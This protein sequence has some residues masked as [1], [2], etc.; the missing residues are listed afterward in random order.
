MTIKN[1]KHFFNLFNDFIV[2]KYLNTIYLFA[3]ITKKKIKKSVNK[4]NSTSF[5][6]F[7]IPF[8]GYAFDNHLL[9]FSYDFFNNLIKKNLPTF[10]YITDLHT[11][12]ITWNTFNYTEQF[13]K[14]NWT[15][16]KKFD[17]FN[18]AIFLTFNSDIK[19]YT[20]NEYLGILKLTKNC[21]SSLMNNLDFSE[22]YFFI[23]RH[24]NKFLKPLKKKNNFNL[25]NQI[26]INKNSQKIFLKFKK[27]NNFKKIHFWQSFFYEL[28]D[29]PIKLNSI[30]VFNEFSK[31]NINSFSKE[32]SIF[33]TESPP[34]PLFIEN[35]PTKKNKIFINKNTILETNIENFFYFK[36]TNNCF[37]F[38]Y[39]FDT[40]T[41]N[42]K[43]IN[44][45]IFNISHSKFISPLWNSR[46]FQYSIYNTFS[47]F[48][49]FI[50]FQ[51]IN[52]TE[53][54]KIFFKNFLNLQSNETIL[55][56]YINCKHAFRVDIRNLILSNQRFE[57]C[58]FDNHFN[59]IPTIEKQIS[60]REYQPHF[61]LK[62]K[63]KSLI[64]LFQKEFFSFLNYKPKI[65][66]N[67]QK[68]KNFNKLFI[69]FNTKNNFETKKKSNNFNQINCYSEKN[70]FLL[71]KNLF[72]IPSR[73]IIFF[74]IKNSIRIEQTEFLKRRLSGYKYP[75]IS[76]E[77]LN[78]KLII[79]HPNNIAQSK[80]IKSI[81]IIGLKHII[82]LKFKQL[83]NLQN[84]FFN[85]YLKL[86]NS[87]SFENR[88]NIHFKS[89]Q[90]QFFFN[91]LEPNFFIKL[92][93]K[94]FESG[95]KKLEENLAKEK[96]NLEENVK[97][98][99]QNNDKINLESNNKINLELNYKKI[100]NY[101]LNFLYFNLPMKLE[102]NSE[103]VSYQEPLK[104]FDFNSKIFN[105]KKKNF[106]P[107]VEEIFETKT[108]FLY[109]NHLVENQQDFN[110]QFYYQN[111]LKSNF[112]D[113][114]KLL[115]PITFLEN[116]LEKIQQIL[117]NKFI[118]KNIL[119]HF[120]SN[121]KIKLPLIYK[122][123]NNF[124]RL[125]HN[126][127]QFKSLKKDIHLYESI[128]EK[129]IS[130]LTQIIF[131]LV[132][133]KKLDSLRKVYQDAINLALESF[134]SELKVESLIDLKEAEYK[135]I[136]ESKKIKFK[137]LAGGAFFLNKFSQ[138]LLLLKNSKKRF[139]QFNI[140]LPTKLSLIK[141]LKIK[142]FNS[143]SKFFLTILSFVYILKKL[144][145]KPKKTIIKNQIEEQFVS[146]GFIIVGPPGSG[147]TVLVK[148]LAGEA[149]VPIII[150]SG[151]AYIKSSATDDMKDVARLKQIFRL[152]KKKA[153]CILFIDEIDNIGQN[154]KDVSTY[155][156]AKQITNQNL[157]PSIKDL[158]KKS[159]RYWQI[160]NPVL[161]NSFLV[162]NEIK[163]EIF[164]SEISNSKKIKTL[165]MLTQFLCE[166][167]GI[168]NRKDIIIIGTTNRLESLDP[169]LIRPGRLDQVV[170]VTFPNKHKRL[171]LLKKSSQ[172][173]NES[174]INW[175]IFINQTS[176][177]TSA[178]I[179]S[180]IQISI[181]KT[182]YKKFNSNFLLKKK[183]N[184]LQNIINKI[185]NQPKFLHDFQTIEYGIEIISTRTNDLQYNSYQN[186][187][188]LNSLIFG[189][190][191]Y[192]K[193]S[194]FSSL[195]NQFF[196][197]THKNYN[198]ILPFYQKKFINLFYTK[199]NIFCDRLKNSYYLFLYLANKFKLKLQK[200]NINLKKLEKNSRNKFYQKYRKYLRILYLLQ[201]K[202]INNI[203]LK[204]NK[205]SLT[206]EKLI[207]STQL[208]KFNCYINRIFKMHL[209]GCQLLT[210]STCSIKNLLIFSFQFKK[211]LFSHQHL[212]KYKLLYSST[213][214]LL[215]NH[216]NL[217]KIPNFIFNNSFDLNRILYCI[218]GKTLIF[219]LLNE[220]NLNLKRL[221]FW[222][223]LQPISEKNNESKKFFQ[224]LFNNCIIKKQFEN[225][226]LFLISGKATEISIIQNYMF[227]NYSNLENYDLQKI[228]WLMSIMIE[229][230]LF[231]NSIKIS[232]LKQINIKQIQ[233]KIKSNKLNT[234]LLSKKNA[235]NKNKFSLN[236][237][238]KRLNLLVALF[239]KHIKNTNNFRQIES[240]HTMPYWWES[241]IKNQILIKKK[242]NNFYGN[243]Y[244]FFMLA[245]A[246]KIQNKILAKFTSYDFYFYNLL[247]NLTSLKN[248]SNKQK[249]IAFFNKKK[250]SYIHDFSVNW[251][252]LQLIESNYIIANLLF[253]SFNKTFKIIE[254]NKEL[255]DCF[256]YYFLCTE[257]LY[258]FE[259]IHFVKN[260]L[261]LK[262]FNKN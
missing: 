56:T 194:I 54:E 157:I 67:F 24:Y 94:E 32:T 23:G 35:F 191:H 48:R 81:K 74:N 137:N 216:F 78:K 57:K 141:V 92:T 184:N 97:T 21:E 247:N 8:V 31:L 62:K 201:N 208:N 102:N 187:C 199:S 215:N 159:N 39:C 133:A 249:L 103:S 173:K 222:K 168:K 245:P 19:F 136:I 115:Q 112:K 100:Q 14:I 45:F 55:K 235:F 59:Q 50:N 13:K 27:F 239:D 96:Q 163:Q 76:R 77:N 84:T 30:F 113:H 126:F 9:L 153:P 5:F 79:H 47:F 256:A 66:Y 227:T 101:I 179:I 253:E 68:K 202:N 154:R 110:T 65:F 218:S 193:K 166:I 83:I 200:N 206:L 145:T 135:G 125:N 36:T 34:Q 70:K 114:E 109:L 12:Q 175:E 192:N 139:N 121:N 209:F 219:A 10:N 86:I 204:K 16:L 28:D 38:P 152:A 190:T 158:K 147:K 33:L 11:R 3:T 75:D 132:I 29:I 143:S 213:N 6:I 63:Q 224:N 231:Y 180:A 241:K 156:N 41:V 162:K 37:L 223:I 252:Q 212:I 22:Y 170:Y 160:F 72:T 134:L 150:D 4:F 61:R 165:S 130:Y 155:F 232:N 228:S 236:L 129:K 52:L 242:L 85:N 220:S 91:S 205:L 124:T 225:Y 214:Y 217:Y 210:N 53:N 182:I 95:L 164:Q 255:L 240:W 46:A 211:V 118:F 198:F 188:Y 238:E 93:K 161:T 18:G 229:K 176:G 203:N 88:D 116:Y 20:N 151:F 138:T 80:L 177:F 207:N 44:K 234:N 186:G 178:D 123:E 107:Y 254:K 244:N 106:Q 51:L 169:A 226:L 144:Q 230:N 17:Y 40:K 149:D 108:P 26:L 251:N 258:D 167:D 117:S 171:E 174:S 262:K 104:I 90:Q 2:L 71:K 87:K 146:K 98:K 131:L 233:R 189:Q 7:S 119:L 105:S 237:F 60:L 1:Q 122:E 42:E 221:S 128:D 89:I 58:L 185:T 127:A 243:W 25:V 248:N 49:K 99:L 261:I 43:Q 140:N 64:P 260:Y 142:K 183:K 82:Y 172:I 250:I 196:I 73:T 197:I 259:I 246:K 148:A 120:E 257:I 15:L 195:I 181:L 69:T 111:E